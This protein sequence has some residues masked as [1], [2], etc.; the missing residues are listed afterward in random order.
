MSNAPLLKRF[1]YL[2]SEIDIMRNLD[3]FVACRAPIVGC[4][5]VVSLP[6]RVQLRRRGTGV[7]PVVRGDLAEDRPK[8]GGH[9][10]GHR[11][12]P[13]FRSDGRKFPSELSLDSGW[14]D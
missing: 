14:N 9:L 6:G 13:S 2:F 12:G 4:S 11:V 7:Q 1:F 10:A 8:L 3:I 5:S